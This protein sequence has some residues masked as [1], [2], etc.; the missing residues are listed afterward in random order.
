MRYSEGCFEPMASSRVWTSYS[1]GCSSTQ[2]NVDKVVSK[3][4]YHH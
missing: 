1:G 2:M 3:Y 4:M